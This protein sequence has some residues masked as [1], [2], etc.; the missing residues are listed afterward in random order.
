MGNI[1]C[2]GQHLE[3]FAQLIY[4]DVFSEMLSTHSVMVL[5]NFLGESKYARFDIVI[6]P[7]TAVSGYWQTDL[8]YRGAIRGHHDI[9]KKYGI[10]LTVLWI[11][12]SF[13]RIL[14]MLIP[15]AILGNVWY[16][17]KN[18]H[19]NYS[20]CKASNWYA[21]PKTVLNVSNGRFCTGVMRQF[22]FCAISYSATRRFLI[23]QMWRLNMYL[24]NRLNTFGIIPHPEAI[25][26]GYIESMNLP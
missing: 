1:L 17:S 13:L 18:L 21:L 2:W 12:K 25:T 7:C 3:N 8:R 26:V 24:L 20:N 14:C 6:F 16:S 5:D 11:L 23:S 15:P 19:W 10:A 22:S 4:F 9:W